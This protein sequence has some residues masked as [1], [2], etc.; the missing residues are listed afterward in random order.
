MFLFTN[1]PHLS[2]S[3]VADGADVGFD[4]TMSEHVSV[5][6]TYLLEKSSTQL[7]SVRTK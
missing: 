2:E 6:M 4:V 3:S 5:Q 1:L 7:Q